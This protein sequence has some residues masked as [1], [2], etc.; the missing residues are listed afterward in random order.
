MG[1][2]QLVGRAH[3]HVVVAEVDDAVVPVV[4]VAVFDVVRR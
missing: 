4:E 3:V 1:L 2:S